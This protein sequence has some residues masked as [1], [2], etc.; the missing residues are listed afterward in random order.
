MHAVCQL[1]LV[2][3]T[4]LFAADDD[5]EHMPRSPGAYFSQLHASAAHGHVHCCAVLDLAGPACVS[6]FA[7]ITAQ[8]LVLSVHFARRLDLA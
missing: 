7:L 3:M 8:L 2:L 1:L 6:H 4:C 5:R